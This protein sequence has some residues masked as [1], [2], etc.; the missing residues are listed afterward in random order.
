MKE[1]TIP[2]HSIIDVITNSST[3]IYTYPCT[4]AVQ[5]ANNIMK[6]LLE[7]LG[8]EG[9]VEDHFDIRLSYDSGVLGDHYYRRFLT[10]E[11]AG[12]RKACAEKFNELYENNDPI[13]L[14]DLPDDDWTSRHQTLKLTLKSDPS[15]DLADKV[16]G[17]FYSEA[18][19]D[20]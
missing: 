3:E 4:N 5:F 15:F 20:G 7:K 10:T 11:F 19:Y 9:S 2:I 1:I 16:S 8:V 17:L 14:V 13:L 18:E 6:E 12:D